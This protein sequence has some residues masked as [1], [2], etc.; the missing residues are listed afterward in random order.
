[1]T[2]IR[3]VT[4]CPRCAEPVY[5]DQM[6][7]HACVT[8][9]PVSGEAGVAASARRTGVADE[10]APAFPKPGPKTKSTHERG[11]TC[12]SCI[13]RRNRRNG[14]ARQNRVAKK[15]GT[16]GAHEE[17]WRHP[18]FRVEVKSGS[19]VPKR[20]L[21][22]MAQSD[23]AKSAGDSRP[24]ITVWSPS[25]S[26]RQIVVMYLDDLTAALDNE[27]PANAFRVRELARSVEKLAKEIGDLAR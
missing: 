10:Y 1:M 6:P 25:N 12:R 14:R 9:R 11:C 24:C 8:V 26:P 27:G 16:S 4:V 3:A 2:E 22:A 19:Q 20:V 18:L 15:L 21:D 7:Y 5:E 17:G 13:N 23:R